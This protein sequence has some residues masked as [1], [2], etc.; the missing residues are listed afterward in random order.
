MRKGESLRLNLNRWIA[1]G[2]S[3]EAMRLCVIKRIILRS[4]DGDPMLLMHFRALNHD[5]YNSPFKTR[6]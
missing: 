6:A 4:L 3:D 5:R 1:D 2:H